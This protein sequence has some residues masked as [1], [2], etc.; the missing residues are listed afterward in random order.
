MKNRGH[1]FWGGA[2]AIYQKVGTQAL[3]PNP[4]VGIPTC[5]LVFLAISLFSPLARITQ[6]FYRD[7]V[8]NKIEVLLFLPSCIL[9]FLRLAH[10]RGQ[11]LDSDL[12]L[13]CF[14]LISFAQYSV[15]PLGQS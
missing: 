10:I 1:R 8:V 15:V 12:Y 7:A 3:S 6:S 9:Q 4:G 2:D 13:K 11:E 14:K 5:I